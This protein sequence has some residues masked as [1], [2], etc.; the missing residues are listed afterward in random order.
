MSL[1]LSSHELELPHSSSAALHAGIQA[2]AH[3]CPRDVVATVIKAFK[4]S[5]LQECHHQNHHHQQLVPATSPSAKG[6]CTSLTNSSTAPGSGANP[7]QEGLE[8]LEPLQGFKDR[9]S[10]LG[11]STMDTPLQQ[12]AEELAGCELYLEDGRDILRLITFRVTAAVALGLPVDCLPRDAALDVVRRVG[13]YF[14]VR[15]NC[16]SVYYEWSSD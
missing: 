15:Y 7:S 16:V 1:L 11:S 13:A 12:F 9:A 14:K 2:L 8:G 3:R 5:L 10:A 6:S 4:L